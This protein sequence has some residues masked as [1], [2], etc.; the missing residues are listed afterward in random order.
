MR[1]LRFPLSLLSALGR[2]Y[3]QRLCRAEASRQT[4]RR[5]NERPVEYRFVFECVRRTCPR[6]VLDVGTGTTALPALLRTCGCVVTAADNIK[7]YWPRG[8]LN[9]HW[10]VEDDDIV[11]TRLPGPYDLITCISVLEHI[12]DHAAAMRNMFRLLAPDG[13]LVLTCP[14]SESEYV[15]NVYLLPEA[16]PEYRDEPYPCRSYSRHELDGWLSGSMA[17]VEVQEYWRIETGRVHALGDWLFPAEEVSKDQ[18]HQ[19]TC[20]LLRKPD[21]RSCPG[22]IE[23]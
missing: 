8:M 14:Y 18:A 12:R 3:V 9:R 6:T 17:Q 10:S 5:H 20:L 23:T 11:A 4:F 13:H 22:R 16:R 2:A 1:L 21:E 15:E 19:L 7:D